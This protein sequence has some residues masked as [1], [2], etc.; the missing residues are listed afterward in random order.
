MIKK[1]NIYIILIA[2][3]YIFI[4]L[5]YV[6]HYYSVVNI[7][8]VCTHIVIQI[9]SIGIYTLELMNSFKSVIF[10]AEV[11]KT[12]LILLVFLYIVS[13]YDIIDK[14]FNF[15][16]SIK[17]VDIN[18]VK[19]SIE[20]IKKDIYNQEKIVKELKEVDPSCEEKIKNAENKKRFLSLIADCPDIVEIINKYINV[21]YKSF[22]IPIALIPNKFKISEIEEIFHTDIKKGSIKIIEMKK[23]IKPIAL[24]VFK[25]LVDRGIIS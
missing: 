23:D 7:N 4:N 3:I 16:T 9:N 24:E 8:S 10:K 22:N 6:Y 12:I 1:K 13:N 21:G 19:I 20:D 18:G 17:Q 2:T 15:I 14:I 25:D 5:I 11:F